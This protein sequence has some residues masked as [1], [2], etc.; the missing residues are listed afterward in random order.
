MRRISW[1]APWW[2]YSLVMGGLAALLRL[3]SS[4]VAGH[5]V[6]VALLGGAFVGLLFGAMM[7]PF[8]AR[9]MKRL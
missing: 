9:R 1:D 5:G 3:V 4:L 2:V 8:T 6:G 7:G